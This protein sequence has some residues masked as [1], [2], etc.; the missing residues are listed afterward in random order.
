MKLKSNIQNLLALI[1]GL[2]ATLLFVVFLL[3][4]PLPW[5]NT[6]ASFTNIDQHFRYGSIGGESSNGL[7]YWIWKVL[8][9]MFSEKLPGK[10][11]TSLGFMQEPGQDL[12]IG[13]AKSKR[14]GLEVV[15]QNCA[16]CHVGQVK[17]SPDADPLIIS[18]MPSHNVDL[19]GY[20]QF[21]R[22]VAVDPRFTAQEIMPYIEA[23]GARLNPLE[24]LLYRFVAIPR[25]RDALVVQGDRL[26]FMERQSPYGPGRVDTFNP[27][28]TLRFNFPKDKL[29]DSELQSISDF[30]PVWQQRSR[31]GMQLH[32]DGNND[33]IDERNKSAAL[34]LVQPT[35]INFPSIHRVR[36]WLLDVPPPAY[37]FAIDPELVAQGKKLYD[38]ACASCHAFGGAKTG[39]VEP[40]ESIGTDPGRLNS[41]TTQLAANQY[42]LF[43]D[44]TYKGEDQR[45]TH[46]RKTNGYSNLPLDGVWLRAPYL[47]NGSVPTL[48]DLLHKPSDRPKLFYRGN[49]LYDPEKVGFVAD[50]PSEKGKQYFPYDTSKPSN[51]NGGHLYGTDLDSADKKAL[52]E[53]LKGI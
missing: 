13:F 18:T 29:T 35:T 20:I 2:V 24:R 4:G 30:P 42:A 15:T 26:S 23:S 50:V 38:N 11:Y 17:T 45:F 43:A 22:T 28:K 39:T 52:I 47:H 16:T 44:I 5:N 12:P 36:D 49:P 9:T 21:L 40:L 53:Y 19:G 6:S 1:G 10:G 31:Q 46:F 33:S 32:W 25:T 8:P 27:Y 37:P 7:P 3:I 51:G 48:W 34:A 14:N 41:Y